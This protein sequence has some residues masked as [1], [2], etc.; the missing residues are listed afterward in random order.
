MKMIKVKNEVLKEA[1]EKNVTSNNEKCK[2]GL[3]EIQ[4]MGNRVS[5][6]NYF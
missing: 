6:N 2:F 3:S 4:F 1:I 5:E